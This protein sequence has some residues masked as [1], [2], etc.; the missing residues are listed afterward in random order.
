MNTIATT[1]STILSGALRVLT[2]C[3]GDDY[4]RFNC[5]NIEG[6]Y[7]ALGRA[8][9]MG[10]PV[11]E[12]RRRLCEDRDFAA[13]SAFN[14]PA[15]LKNEI[16]S[17]DPGKWGALDEPGG[18]DI[19]SIM[20]Y[21]SFAFID[22]IDACGESHDHCTLLRIEKDGQG[23]EVDTRLIDRPKKPSIGDVVWVKKNYCWP[24]DADCT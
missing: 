4:V 21:S 15:F 5:H 20:H 22:N 3:L 10:N 19:D 6:S 14:S 9:S 2:P 8:M 24:A 16:L 17:G 1:V 12:A 11:I 18:Y 13:Q 7:D 23:N